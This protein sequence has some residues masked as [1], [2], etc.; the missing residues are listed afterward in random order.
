MTI[1][2]YLGSIT[3]N[4]NKYISTSEFINLNK[5]GLTSLEGVE[6]FTKAKKIYINKN[7]L[8]SLKGIEKL[9]NLEAIECSNNI[10]E[11]L[12]GIE[13][14]KNLRMVYCE[15]NNI[16]SLK[17]LI[18]L[19]NLFEICVMGNPLPKEIRDYTIN[20]MKTYYRTIERK[21]KIELIID[22]D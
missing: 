13:K 4:D 8:T 16:T 7:N 9:P 15:N 20:E 12:E 6:V 1:T 22:N 18:N 19:N 5:A 2:E 10:I 17:E 14:L 21:R 11:S 3:D